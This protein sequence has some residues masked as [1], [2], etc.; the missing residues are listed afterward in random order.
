MGAAV[1]KKCRDRC[2][3]LDEGSRGEVAWDS[4]TFGC[5]GFAGSQARYGL[6][7]L[8]DFVRRSWF[9]LFPDRSRWYGGLWSRGSR[10]RLAGAV[11]EVAK[12]GY[13]SALAAAQAG[14][15]RARW[16]DRRVGEHPPTACRSPTPSTSPSARQSGSS[17]IPRID[18]TTWMRFESTGKSSNRRWGFR[19]ALGLAG[20]AV[21]ALLPSLADGAKSVKPAGAPGVVGSNGV[22]SL[23]G[24]TEKTVPLRTHSLYAR[25]PRLSL[26]DRLTRVR[27]PDT[28]RA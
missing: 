18:N 3:W 12:E 24:T 22:V 17:S 14:P 25:K 16:A 4:G 2:S 15:K 11:M 19:S 13:R 7:Y 6:Q 21:V 23:R 1:V 8:V 26:I 10:V 27:R 20:L 28:A 5:E 9:V